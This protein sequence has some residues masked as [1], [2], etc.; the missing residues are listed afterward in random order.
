MSHSNSDGHRD[1]AAEQ[2][3]RHLDQQAG[4]VSALAVGVEAAAMGE[5][6]EGLRAER[7]RLVA[8]LRGGDKAHAAGCPVRGEVPRPGKA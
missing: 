8:Q 2:A 1:V 5:P 6:G 7:D 3:L 4:A